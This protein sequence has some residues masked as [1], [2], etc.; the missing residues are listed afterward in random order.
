MDSANKKQLAIGAPPRPTSFS[1]KAL[2]PRPGVVQTR[3][4][5]ISDARRRRPRMFLGDLS[6]TV[7]YNRSLNKGNPIPSFSIHGPKI[8]PDVSMLFM[9]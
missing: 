1:S 7:S 4:A 2:V 8:E 3:K 5:S 6:N 9:T